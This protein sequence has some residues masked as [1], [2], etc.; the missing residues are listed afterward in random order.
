LLRTQLIDGIVYGPDPRQGYVDANVFYHPALKFQFP[1]LSGWQTANSP[2]QFR[3]ASTDKKAM[4]T[5]TLAPE[6]T[7]EAAAQGFP[8]ENQLQIVSQKNVTIGGLPAIIQYCDQVPAQAQQGQQQ[9]QQQPAAE[10]ARILM[11]YIEYN[12]LIYKL[13]GVAAAKDFSGYERLFANTINGFQVLTDATKIN[14]LPERI[15]IQKTTSDMT[16]AAAMQSYGMPEKR[17]KELAILNQ[18]E[19]TELVPRGTSVKTFQKTALKP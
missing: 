16:F 18:M 5:L 14:V 12:G 7:L 10:L 11:S 15:K 19:L 17:L 13:F 8:K 3:M 6:K 1:V 2:S 4:M 9:Q